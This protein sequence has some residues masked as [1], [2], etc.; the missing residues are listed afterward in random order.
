[1]RTT[2]SFTTV[3]QM[4][5]F[6]RRSSVT[7][8]TWLNAKCSTCKEIH[9]MPDMPEPIWANT[10]YKFWVDGSHKWK[11]NVDIY[12]S[13]RLICHGKQDGSRLYMAGD[14]FSGY[15]GWVVGALQTV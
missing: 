12:D 13:M 15:Q 8:S 2:S 9:N 1:M 14:A 6:G 11:I 10:L 4:L 7:T 3:A 5:S